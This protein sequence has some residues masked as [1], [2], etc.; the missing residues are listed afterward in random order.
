MFRHLVSDIRRVNISYI[1][2]LITKITMAVCNE[3]G[4]VFHNKSNLNRHKRV[5]HAQAVQSDE[6]EDDGGVES[7]VE[8]DE[9]TSDNQLSS[10]DE[11]VDVWKVITDEADDDDGGVLEA[12][13]RN[14]LFCRSLKRDETYKAV[15]STLENAK[16]NDDMDFEEA[17]DYAVDKRKFLI[18]RSAN[19]ANEVQH[20]EEKF[21]EQ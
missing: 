19:E 21:N 15:I 12:F 16:N 17:L 14:V 9:T 20:E 18:N 11:E 13:K 3:C 6:S 10:D 5:M 8:E 1:Y 4:K 2:S 7:T